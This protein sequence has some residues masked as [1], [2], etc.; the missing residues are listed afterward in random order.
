[1]LEL[2]KTRFDEVESMLEHKYVAVKKQISFAGDKYAKYQNEN[3]LIEL[4]APVFSPCYETHL[5]RATL[6]GSL[7]EKERGGI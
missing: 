5:F 2:D 1:M 7:A 6:S 4:D 3:D